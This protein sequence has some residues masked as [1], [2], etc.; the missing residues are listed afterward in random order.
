MLQPCLA[1]FC[2]FFAV[3][4]WH[5]AGAKTLVFSFLNGTLISLSL[6]MQPFFE[7]LRVKTRIDGTKSGFGRVFAALRTMAIIMFLRYFLRAGSLEVALVMIKRTAYHPRLY[8]LWDGT[9]LKFG[10]SLEEYLVFIAGTA[11][12]LVRDFITETGR[13][14]N[15]WINSL[16]PITQFV[17]LLVALLSLIIFGVYSGDA[18]SAEFIYANY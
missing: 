10:L 13:K 15:Q 14:C 4:I 8:E 1:T 18:V 11:V 9:L 17:L 3:G 12:L 2:V 5:G 16:M 6:F 7:K